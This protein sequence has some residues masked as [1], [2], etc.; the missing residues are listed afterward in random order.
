V[1][2]VVKRGHE[3]GV[4]NM[5]VTHGFTTVAGLTMEEAK[6][7]VRRQGLTHPD[8]MEAAIAA[9]KREGI[10]DADIDLMVRKNPARL[11]GLAD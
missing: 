6:Q 10:G 4:K 2:A 8:G 9:M 11:L 7:G 5:V 1:V 3:L